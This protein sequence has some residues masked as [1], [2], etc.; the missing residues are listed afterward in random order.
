VGTV[1]FTMIQG[2]SPRRGPY[3]ESSGRI[4][5]RSNFKSYMWQA[6]HDDAVCPFPLFI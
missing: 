1:R 5:G 2:A 6:D 4:L 3:I